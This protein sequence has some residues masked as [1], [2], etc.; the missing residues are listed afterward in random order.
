MKIPK[1]FLKIFIAFWA[2]S[3]FVML[4]SGFTIFSQIE[5]NQ[6]HRYYNNAIK[7]I[8]QPLIEQYEFKNTPVIYMPL[9]GPHKRT[10]HHHKL[11]PDALIDIQYQEQSI[12]ITTH[13]QEIKNKR[14]TLSFTSKAGHTYQIIALKP[15]LPPMFMPIFKRFAHIQ[16]LFIL[17]VSC[18]VSALLSWSI[19]KPLNQLSLATRQFS[20]GDHSL[21]IAPHWQHQRDEIGILAQ[22]IA[23]M[24]QRI[25]TILTAQNQ[26]LHHVSH[27][28]RAPLSRLQVAAE[29]LRQD[30]PLGDRY[31]ERIHM[32]CQR[33][34]QMI[35]RILHMARMESNFKPEQVDIEA[36]INQAIHNIQFEYPDLKIEFKTELKPEP[37]WADPLLLE[38]ALDNLLRN[39]VVHNSPN[40]QIDIT[41]ENYGDRQLL[42][43][44]DYGQGATKEEL[45][46]LGTPFYR[47]GKRMHG[48]GFGLGLSITREIMKHH[49][50]E[51]ILSNHEQGGLVATLAFN[52]TAWHIKSIA[53]LQN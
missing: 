52:L 31:V 41:L 17:I 2:S 38:E 10:K 15:R 47:G 4:A 43:V 16:F 20:L 14:I 37:L 29:L 51:L 35:H 36:I 49:Q 40:G 27:E 19:T 12:L 6:F 28:L 23:Q 9:S 25:K 24:I 21:E 3:L 11:P 50:G 7:R 34:D 32:E 48:E 22:D 33:M 26:L 42:S 53:P 8:A 44:R 18:L 5:S 45:E 46:Q 13:M 1:L 30:N 39:A